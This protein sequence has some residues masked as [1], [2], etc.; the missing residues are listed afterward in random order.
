MAINDPYSPIYMN[1]NAARAGLWD[2]RMMS[3]ANRSETPFERGMG[4]SYG[5]PLAEGGML[6]GIASMANEPDYSAFTYDPAAHAAAQKYLGQFGLSPLEA[7]QVKQNQ[8]LPNTGFFGNHPQLSRALEGAAFAGMAAHGG[9]TPGESIQGALSGWLG[10]NRLRQGMYN[11]QFAR[12]FE[13][14]GMLEGMQD[15]T[16]RR[17]LQGAQ[18]KRYE[19]ESDIQEERVQLE[20]Q[21]NE[22]GYDKLNATRPVPVE[23]GT[24][25]YGPQGWEFKEGPGKAPRS[26]GNDFDKWLAMANAE[27]KAKGKPE[28]NSSEILDE[29]GK[30]M[31]AGVV[32]GTYGR[33][34]AELGY[35]N[36]QEDERDKDREVDGYKAQMRKIDDP[37]HQKWAL[38]AIVQQRVGQKPPA[39]APKDW[40]W[41]PSPADTNAFINQY[42]Q[43]LQN[44]IDAVNQAFTD[45]WGNA[46]NATPPESKKPA[47]QGKQ[48]VRSYMDVKPH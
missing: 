34:N 44:K 38:D 37:T 5:H 9:N 2:M 11:Q 48:K 13:A 23:G 25:L 45:K 31:S 26:A 21:K 7:N 8:L 14:A 15:A 40:M 41:N 47:A 36:Y 33:E 1:P 42:N 20:Q 32:P 24:Y 19:S 28:M 43:Q 30:W 22:L 17:E 12:P 39:G 35:K 10:G 27:R 16:Q 46:A 29:R 18:I 6:G 3:A 4:H